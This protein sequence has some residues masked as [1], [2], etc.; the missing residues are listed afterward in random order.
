MYLYEEIHSIR[1]CLQPSRDN[2]Y[3]LESI[4]FDIFGGTFGFHSLKKYP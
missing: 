4:V 1:R 2:S 3:L